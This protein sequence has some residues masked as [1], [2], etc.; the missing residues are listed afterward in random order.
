MSEYYLGVLAGLVASLLWSINPGLISL[1][2]KKESTL[3]LNALRG[4]FAALVLLV[5]VSLWS[6][7]Y[8]G[9]YT[10]FAIIYLSAFFGPLLGDLFY[11]HSIKSI[12]GGNAVAISYSYI[13]FAQFFSHFFY[14][15][16]VSVR[17]VVGAV[18]ALIGIQLVYY[19]EKSRFGLL[20]FALALS[21]AISWG[22][23]A[24]LSK[25]A[26]RYGD[27]LVIA[28]YRNLS[29]FISLLPFTLGNKYNWFSKNALIIG[30]VSGG[31]GFGVGMTM[32]LYGIE[33]VG[34]SLTTLVTSLTPVLGRVIA[35]H[36]AGEAASPQAY[37]GTLL[38][39][40]G[41]VIGVSK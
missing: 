9:G 13:F 35:E 39:S 34:V 25:L 28:F 6:S 15:E 23:G 26:L 14:G 3:L 38:S 1:L 17:L 20:G 18:L 31:L 27:P 40:I 36:M 41:I 22:L 24:T 30:L 7:F 37:L 4:L 16:K 33:K 5:P 29:V 8:I 10:G 32:F 2:G 21:A 11:I 12:G 19:G